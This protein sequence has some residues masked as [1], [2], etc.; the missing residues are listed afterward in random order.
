MRLFADVRTGE[1]L[2]A[3]LLAT[4]V[5]LILG[6]YYMIR[7][8][9]DGIV[10][11][12]YGPELKIYLQV[13]IV[14][15]LA[16]LVP[17][18]GK[19]ADR[20]PRRRL[21]NLVSWII[22]ALL[23]VFAAAGAVGMRIGIPFFVYGSIFNV[24]V[25]AQFWSFAN[26]I[27]KREEGERLFPVIAVGA[28]LGAAVG[29]TFVEGLIEPF[30]LY[31]PMV[32]AAVVLLAAL[33]I[34]NYV[35]TRERRTREAGLP[36]VKT[37]ATLAA[38]GAFQAPKTI[39]ELEE[40]AER[41]RQLY[42]ARERSE[43]IEDYEQAGSGMSAFQLVWRTRYLLLIGLLVLFLN[44]VNTVGGYIFD[45][46]LADAA[47]AAVEAGTAGGL[48]RGEWLGQQ[49]A[50]FYSVMNI[51]G[52]LI[53]LFITSRVVKYLGV[54]WGLLLLPLFSLGAYSVIALIP[55]LAVVRW[56][57]TVENATD[58]SLY[59]TLRAMLFLP[60]TRE[61]K[62]KAKQVTDSFSQRAGDV[63]SAGIVFVGTMLGL[64]L[65]GFAIVNIVLVLGWLYVAFAIGREYDSL[66]A[67][68][69]PPQ[70]R[71]VRLAP[72]EVG[73]IR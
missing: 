36:D 3:V 4:N 47:T 31:V 56:A 28:S 20:F 64:S 70:P 52:L 44:W 59:N 42:E 24:M 27:Y 41:E 30:G 58:Y 72:T 12:E 32:I 25:V 69:K 26:D 73:V 8:M 63:L 65:L 68:G 23:V 2:T 18:Y 5:F 11:A 7:P 54:R 1:G 13:V 22:S 46:V 48:D 39:E 19:L 62:Y 43:A 60:T 10:N 61:Q 55:S 50:S 57:K 15:I 66:V 37:T 35:D 71:Q 38:T 51:V 40:L 49:Y 29:A 67:S 21:I 33:L 34:T 14:A 16:M 45:A 17:A 9:R 6:A 53:Q